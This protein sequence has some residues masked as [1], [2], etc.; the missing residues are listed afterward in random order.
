MECGP[1]RSQRAKVRA[2]TAGSPPPPVRFD[3]SAPLSYITAN[4]SIGGQVYPNLFRVKHWFASS[5]RPERVHALLI[6]LLPFE[7]GWIL[8]HFSVSEAKAQSI[9]F[10]FIL[11]MVRSE[12]QE[13]P[14]SGLVGVPPNLQVADAEGHATSR[15][16]VKSLLGFAAVAVSVA[17]KARVQP[18]NPQTIKGNPSLCILGRTPETTELHGGDH[19]FGPS[20]D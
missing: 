14:A 12:S 11:Q 3:G 18:P 8:R 6:L 19:R 1:Q 15:N 7:E 13:A 9:T 4:E 16:H 10:P 17:Q 2:R 5:R 20:L